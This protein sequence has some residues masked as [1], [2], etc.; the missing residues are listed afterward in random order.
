MARVYP[1]AV[2]KNE[3]FGRQS[4]AR[5]LL[6]DTL[7]KSLCRLNGPQQIL[8]LDL[9]SWVRYADGI[10][11]HSEM[12][13]IISKV[14]DLTQHERRFVRSHRLILTL[15]LAPVPVE[16]RCGC[17]Q[18]DPMCSPTVC[19]PRWA[20][21]PRHVKIGHAQPAGPSQVRA[22]YMYLVHDIL[23]TELDP[24]AGIR[25]PSETRA[26]VVGTTCSTAPQMYSCSLPHIT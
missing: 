16:R 5:T 9:W 3:G 12:Q 1:E 14:V 21:H 13:G 18:A 7:T 26:M 15:M 8:E 25:S 10:C 20:P 17:V 22:N 6:H 24:P 4:H 19:M 11:W 2:T 23:A